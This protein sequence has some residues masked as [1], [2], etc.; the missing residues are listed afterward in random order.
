MKNILF[1]A[2]FVLIQG[3]SQVKQDPKD[4]IESRWDNQEK[5]YRI[6][7]SG[8]GGSY[9]TLNGWMTGGQYGR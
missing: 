8:C 1:L 7:A 6:C 4:N 9:G 2:T 5:L 3:C